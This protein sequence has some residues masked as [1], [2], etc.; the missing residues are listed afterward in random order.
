V[1]E[2][3]LDEIRPEAVAARGLD[4]AAA[5]LLVGK[6]IAEVE[7]SADALA[8]LVG[9]RERSGE[10]DQPEGFFSRAAADKLS[11]RE[12]FLSALVGQ[13]QPQAQQRDERGR[14]SGGFDGGA[15]QSPPP[16]TP[17]HDQTLAQLFRSKAA[18]VGR[19]I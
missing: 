18:D 19:S 3:Q 16:P 12:A 15:R 6:S 2:P 14:F 13:P 17:T 11:R 7:A 5:R 10:H 4:P 1:N 8:A 9:Q